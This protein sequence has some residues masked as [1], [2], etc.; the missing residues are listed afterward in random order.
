MSSLSIAHLKLRTLCTLW[1][2]GSFRPDSAQ[3]NLSPKSDSRNVPVRIVA[4]S[5]FFFETRFYFSSARCIGLTLMSGEL[6]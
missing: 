4:V 6:L 1:E 5:L 2:G 3:R